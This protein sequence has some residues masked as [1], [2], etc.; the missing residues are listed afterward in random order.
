MNYPDMNDFERQSRRAADQ[1]ILSDDV[2]EEI[3]HIPSEVIDL[4]DAPPP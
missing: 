2:A 3:S 4:A 1:E